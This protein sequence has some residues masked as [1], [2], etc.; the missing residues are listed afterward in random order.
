M[1][2]THTPEIST[3]STTTESSTLARRDVLR[4]GAI[5]V[6]ALALATL[7]PLAEATQGETPDPSGM[8]ASGTMDRRMGDGTNPRTRARNARE[9]GAN[10]A[11]YGTLSLMGS[12]MALTKATDPDVKEFAGFEAT[13]QRAVA[14]ILTHMGVK[15]P[16]D[17]DANSRAILREHEAA[18]GA[19]FDKVYAKAQLKAHQDLLVLM[20]SLLQ[21]SKSN[22][23]DEFAARQVATLATAAVKEHIALSGKLVAKLGA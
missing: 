21:N 12:E 4:T 14:E 13:E 9:W 22:A 2:P 23:K 11:Q 6:A 17:L 10:L 18:T 19:E 16:A 7:A 5:G 20:E 1:E 8:K 3:P 15:V